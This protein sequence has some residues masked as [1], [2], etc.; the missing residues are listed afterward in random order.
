[1]GKTSQGVRIASADWWL[2]NKIK[3]KTYKIKYNTKYNSCCLDK[4]I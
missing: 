4:E 2:S 1:M 3:D